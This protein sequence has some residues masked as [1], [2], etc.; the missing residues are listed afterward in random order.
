MPLIVLPILTCKLDPGGVLILFGT[1]QVLAGLICRLPI[2]VHP[3]KAMVAIAIAENLS[4]PVLAGG[5]LAA[6]TRF[7]TG[8]Q[9]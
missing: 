8:I 2:P 4:A 7:N 3:L 6:W 9:P 5:G 1:C